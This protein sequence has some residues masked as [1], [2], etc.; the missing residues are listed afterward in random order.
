MEEII[1]RYFQILKHKDPNK[2]K[3][4]VRWLVIGGICIILAVIIYNIK[5]PELGLLG[6]ILASFIGFAALYILA[7]VVAYKMHKNEDQNK[8]SYR[9]LDM[10]KQY[11]T[12][13]RQVF[14]LN[15]TP[16]IVYCE[17]LFQ[18]GPKV[19]LVVKDY[20]KAFFELDP[21]IKSHC[22]ILLEAHAMSKTLDS[23]T[24]RLRKF[25]KPTP[26]NGMT[27][28][29]YSA[30]SSYLAHLL[31]NRALD[32]LIDDDLTIRKLYENDKKLRPLHRS[33]LSNHFGINALVFLK[34]VIS[35]K[36]A[37]EELYNEKGWLLL[38][39]RSH[40]ASIAKN[41]LTAS[42]AT[43][44]KM[45][46]TDIFPNEYDDILK[47]EYIR[48]GC[49]E[50]SLQGAIWVTDEWI[51]AQKEKS[52]DAKRK[53]MKINFLG[54]SRDIYEGGKPT[55][56]YAV[57]LDVTLEEYEAGRALWDEKKAMEKAQQLEE[58]AAHRE[59]VPTHSI[60]EVDMIYIADWSSVKMQKIYDPDT[61]KQ[62]LP[63]AKH[64]D[65]RLDSAGLEFDEKDTHCN[66]LP[67]EPNL[68]SNFWFLEGCPEPAP[69]AKEAC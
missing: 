28:T 9:N 13:Y 69:S 62:I 67:F 16:F 37:K 29:I 53:F 66:P 7:Q 3:K 59:P 65:F 48:H 50:D 1:R 45:E 6:N 49:V 14:N 63:E 12:R 32:Y 33:A 18:Y 5:C 57:Y 15:G 21:Y 64:C 24:V 20:P 8:V 61:N 11:G 52:Q 19:H 35:D 22:D 58:K 47:E 46:N 51:A 23:V 42:I 25:D 60:D 38:P 44:L 68:I 34:K 54:L 26:E 39:H 10:W 36:D 27:A 4:I 31:T 43:R 2:Y 55:L 17:P 30:R 41:S 40:D 56:F